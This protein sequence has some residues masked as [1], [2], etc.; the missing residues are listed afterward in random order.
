MIITAISLEKRKSGACYKI[1]KIAKI[2][3]GKKLLIPWLET[4]K[5]T[6]SSRFQLLLAAATWTVVGMA[7]L[8][9]GGN[10]ILI[11][12]NEKALFLMLAGICIGLAKSLLILDRTAKKVVHRI[13][14]R[15]E[16]HCLGGFLSLSNWALI[17]V[18]AVLGKLLRATALP[19]SLLGLI[20]IAVGIGLLISS[21]NIWWVWK[22]HQPQES[23]THRNE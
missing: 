23:G 21:R 3:T 7:L 4:C 18:M 12:A 13:K 19:R 6:A 1:K 9:V 10:W 5:P 8:V 16:N 17:A 11:Q 15:G 22:S 20:Y 14:L 2:I